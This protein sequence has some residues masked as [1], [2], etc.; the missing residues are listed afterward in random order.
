MPVGEFVG[1]PIAVDKKGA[2]PVRFRWRG[3]E[4]L[5][6]R[7][8]QSWFDVGCGPQGRH[9]RK[10]WWERRRRTF[11]RVETPDGELFEIYWDR[12]SGRKDWVLYRRLH[13]G[14]D[15]TGGGDA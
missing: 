14:G 9:I 11:Y 1:E 6:A 10:G 3:R 15:L 2:E 8:R 7:V 4:Y 5:V 13:D 12:G